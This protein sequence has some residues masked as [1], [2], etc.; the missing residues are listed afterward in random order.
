L[1]ELV[2]R[3]ADLLEHRLELAVE[4]FDALFNELDAGFDP[5]H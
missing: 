4:V 3:G 2:E 1:V 5:A